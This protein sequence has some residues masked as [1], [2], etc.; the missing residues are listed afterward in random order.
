VARGILT[1]LA[2]AIVGGGAACG[3]SPSKPPVVAF[4]VDPVT[5]PDA[6]DSGA[7]KISHET[8]LRAH[9]DLT[10]SITVTLRALPWAPPACGGDASDAARCAARDA[11]LSERQTLDAKEVSCVVAAFGP[12]GSIKMV[13]P[14][15]YEPPRLK[16]SG[17][18]VPV[19][20]AF[21]VRASWSQIQEV[22][23]H[24]YVERIDPAP[25]EAPKLGLT[26]P[27]IPG[28]CPAADEAPEPK[29]G[30][31]AIQGLGRQPVVFDLR[32][33]LMPAL[34]S[35]AGTDCDAAY[36]AGW[37]RTIVAR[38]ML[39]CVR[40]WIDSKATAETPDVPY[41][42]V[43]GIPDGPH[44]PPFDDGVHALLSFG[45]GLTWEEAREVARHPYIGHLWTSTSL[46]FG[47]LPP[48]C[49]PDY[50]APVQPPDCNVTPESI[51]GKFLAQSQATWEA[52]QAPNEVMIAV[53]RTGSVCPRPACPGRTCPELERYLARLDQETAASQT[54]VRAF[55]ASIG[56]TASPEVFTAGNG[57]SATLTWP[58]IQ[59]VAAHPHVQQ[60][61]PRF[62]G[63]APVGPPPP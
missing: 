6:R 9:P 35:C 7:G 32:Q 45:L 17:V 12:P 43:D 41:A 37:Q 11:A 27:P 31:A 29:L 1:S 55:I 8:F 36:A 13:T 56:G 26:P 33:D 60:I 54:C 38:R 48:G 39:T 18:P 63:P 22:A 34:Q 61:D 58:Q 47:T 2:L 4:A 49:P 23:R 5:C 46:S 14:Y 44:L 20:T 19:G 16:T 62:G 3:G 30:D 25:G 57:I 50:D 59:M 24:P 52:S 21:T 42:T 53:R 40:S 28:E 15:W 51:D 10:H